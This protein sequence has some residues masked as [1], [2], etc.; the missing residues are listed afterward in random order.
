V[1]IDTGS[2][3]AAIKAPKICIAHSQRCTNVRKHVISIVSAC[4]A[5]SSDV[6]THSYKGPT[7]AAL[8]HRVCVYRATTHDKQQQKVLVELLRTVLGRSTQHTLHIIAHYSTWVL[9]HASY[10]HI[11]EVSSSPLQRAC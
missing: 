2:A 4:D 9:P 3:P 7:S 5:H 6:R 1:N 10:K 11:Q 8:Q